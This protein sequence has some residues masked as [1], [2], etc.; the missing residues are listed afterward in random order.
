MVSCSYITNDVECA[1]TP[2]CNWGGSNCTGIAQPPGGGGGFG[3]FSQFAGGYNSA[4]GLNSDLTTIG[5]LVSAR[6]PGLSIVG[7]SILLGMLIYGGFQMLTAA[8]NPDKA[9]AGQKILTTAI[10]GF[11]ILFVGY[12]IGQIL[13]IAK[14]PVSQLLDDYASSLA[15]W[16][17]L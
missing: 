17:N 3:A 7:G 4:I 11:F 13:Q 6:L 1:S 2:G 9:A 5:G 10:A 16:K 8:G 15:H 14:E 12:W